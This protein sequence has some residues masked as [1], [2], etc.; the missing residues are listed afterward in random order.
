[1]CECAWAWVWEKCRY[2]LDGKFFFLEFMCYIC[3][4]MHYIA[5]VATYIQVLT[6][7]QQPQIEFFLWMR[8]VLFYFNSVQ[9]SSRED[10]FPSLWTFQKKDDSVFFR[11]VKKNNYQKFFA[12]FKTVC[13]WLLF[14]F[15]VCFSNK[16][17]VGGGKKGNKAHRVVIK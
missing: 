9:F 15:Y 14:T 13:I 6:L 16:R 3:A 2:V 7:Q 4:C 10:R 11:D 5:P 1:M 8:T 12:A 17:E